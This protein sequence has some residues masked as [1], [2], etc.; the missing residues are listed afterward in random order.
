MPE[1]QGRVAVVVVEQLGDLPGAMLVEVT[2]GD[3]VITLGDNVPG[4]P[5]SDDV[6]QLALALIKRVNTEYPTDLTEE[7]VE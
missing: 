3:D 4:G 6:R 5:L 2:L 1:Q 7:V